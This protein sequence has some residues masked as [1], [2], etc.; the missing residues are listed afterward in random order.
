MHSAERQVY[1]G[2]FDNAVP[3]I[4]D[5]ACRTTDFRVE[6]ILSGMPVPTISKAM[7]YR[8]EQ[9]TNARCKGIR[10]RRERI[11]ARRGIPNRVYSDLLL[12]SCVRH[13][14]AQS[15]SNGYSGTESNGATETKVRPLNPLLNFTVPSIFENI[16]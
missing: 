15:R 7:F 11:R 4:V 1:Q 8:W 14:I 12:E 6:T 13:A 3:A 9:S 16:V 10:Q 2:F 5:M